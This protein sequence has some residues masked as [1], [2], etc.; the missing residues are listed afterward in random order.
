MRQAPV[1]RW[2]G[3]RLTIPSPYAAA[4]LAVE[5][6]PA[7]VDGPERGLLN[8]NVPAARRSNIRGIRWAGLGDMGSV[9]S[10]I[11]K[12]ETDWLQFDFEAT[13]HRADEDTDLATV[14][15]GYAA[16][17]SIHGPAE[18]WGPQGAAGEEF[19]DG[20]GIHGASAGH[21]LRPS[22]SYFKD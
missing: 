1:P 12:I 14:R 2:G 7:V 19:A 15:V 6:L 11:V 9:R 5:L 3:Y 18:V 13:D 17:T 20:H 8:L 10:A 21:E 16:I 22:R 4:N